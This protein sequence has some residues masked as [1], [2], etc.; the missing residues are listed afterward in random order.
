MRHGHRVVDRAEVTSERGMVVAKHRLASEA[1]ARMLEAGGNAVD[2]AIAA[3]FTSGVVEPMMSGLGGGGVMI[4]HDPADGRDWCVEFGMRG[5]ALATPGCWELDEGRSPDVFKWRRVKHDANIVGHR[6][7]AVPGAVAGYALALERWGKLPLATVIQPAIE[8]AANGVPVSWFHSLLVTRDLAK[9]RRLPQTA[10]IFLNHRDPPVSASVDKDGDRL[11]QTELARALETIAALGP[12][13]FYRGPLAAAIDREMREGDGLLRAADLA[14]YRARIIPALAVPY[15]QTRVATVPGPFGGITM[16]EMLRILDGFDLAALGHNSADVLHTVAE[17]SLLAFSDR[18]AYLADP[19]VVPA[20]FAGLLAEAYIA[21]RRRAINPD[22]ATGARSPGDPWRHEPEGR[23]E[24]A[25]AATGAGGPESRDTTHLCA[26]D[27]SGMVVSLTSTLMSSFGS[28]VVVPG[29]GILL[30]NGM[31]WF[32]PEPGRPASVGPSR[33]PLT[34]QTPAL[35]VDDQ[36]PLLAVGASGGRRI[37]D[38]VAQLI[39]KV[40]DFGLSAQ[41]AIASPR[42][43]CS[44]QRLVIDDRVELDVL[45][46]LAA[47]G[48]DVLAVENDFL[49][50]G[51]ASPVAIQ[52][53]R[54]SGRLRGG[55]DP[56]YPATAV[57]L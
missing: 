45:T 8:A 38:A 19:D 17:A 13:A 56:Y 7:A 23:L 32:D 26:A 42:M 2:A 22:R 1:G 35:V 18:F 28:G 3:A 54:P 44:E 53:E 30:N 4:V 43:D 52:F 12:D 48:H 21:E 37:L 20:P 34:N 33:R 29:T 9:L 10:A 6:S 50:G 24:A 41:A 27:S 36:G 25:P 46:A 5:P 51:F 11:T 14:S 57:G 16:A 40:V 39:I 15:R 55:A 47:R 31:A 49:A